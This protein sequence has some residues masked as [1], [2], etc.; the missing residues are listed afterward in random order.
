M[1]TRGEQ[2][3][4]YLL[5][6]QQARLWFLQEAL[7]PAGFRTQFAVLIEGALEK[8]R[9]IATLENMVERHTILGARF[10]R[11]AN[12]RAP[13]Q[14]IGGRAEISFE[15]ISLEG[16]AQADAAALLE[17][18]FENSRN[19]PINFETEPP[20]KA[21][22]FRL[23]ANKHALLISLPSLCADA[24]SARIIFEDMTRRYTEGIEPTAGGQE[25][26]QYIQFAE[27]QN[28]LLAGDENGA[29]AGDTAEGSGSPAT[30][31]RM[32][33]ARRDSGSQTLTLE[34]QRSSIDYDVTELLKARARES[35]V[36]ASSFMLACW[37][38]LVW[39]FSGE[40]EPSIGYMTDGRQYEELVSMPGLIDHVAPL[41]SQL[42]K[43]DAFAE[44]LKRTEAESLHANERRP[45]GACDL[46]WMRRG[47]ASTPHV[48]SSCREPKSSLVAAFRF[49]WPA[50]IV[51][52]NRSTSGYSALRASARLPFVST[53]ILE[54]TIP[55]ISP[56]W[57]TALW[58]SSRTRRKTRRSRSATCDC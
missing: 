51:A 36:S 12:L 6:P 7:Q 5:S 28:N 47:R 42:S 43:S 8:K 19:T 30:E 16:G 23:R 25:T 39:R 54:F 58:Q 48:S 50:L 34:T 31:T 55:S 37:Q 26:F 9:L 21:W 40:S 35:N 14:V 38:V 20:L 24:I 11:T 1:K 27:W 4:G 45:S 2:V 46:I 57:W 56:R 17:E 18:R 13:A 44:V 10:I 29:G 33:F 53:S 22:L 3:E 32:S 52:P 41:R 49:R 15:E